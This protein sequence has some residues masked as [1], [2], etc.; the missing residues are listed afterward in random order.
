MV[1]TRLS[2]RD[3]HTLR[4]FAWNRNASLA[5][6]LQITFVGYAYVLGY[7]SLAWVVFPCLVGPLEHWQDAWRIRKLRQGPHAYLVG[8]IHLVEADALDWRSL[9]ALLC[10]LTFMYV[11]ALL[12]MGPY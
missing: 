11:S 1:H 2:Y 8:K 4:S 5:S 3:V 7:V 10:M 6:L 9:A 12:T